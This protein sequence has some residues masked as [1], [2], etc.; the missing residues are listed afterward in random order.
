MIPSKPGDVQD[1][2]KPQKLPAFGGSSLSELLQ[3]VERNEVV[4][5]VFWGVVQGFSGYYIYLYDIWSK[6]PYD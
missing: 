2:S 4:G 6:S 3:C 5:H 1:K